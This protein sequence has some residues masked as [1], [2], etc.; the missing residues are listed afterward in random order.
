MVNTK[1]FYS[2][3]ISFLMSCVLNAQVSNVP[4]AVNYQ[5]VARTATGSILGNANISVRMTINDGINPGFTAYQETHTAIT[6]Q[7]G[8]FTIKIG[9]GNP[10]I[11]VF[12]NINWATGNKYLLV[13]YDP[14]GGTN[15]LNMGSTQLLSVPYA[16][17]AEKSGGTATPG[18][19]GPT[20]PQGAAGVPGPQGPAGANGLNGAIGTQGPVGATGAQ[21]I[22][23]VAGPTG[24]QGATGNNGVTGAVGAT[25]ATGAQGPIGPTGANGNNGATGAVGATGSTGATGATGATGT[26]GLQGSTGVSGAQGLTGLAGPTGPGWI[27][28]NL[29]YN[30]DGSLNLATTSPQ[31]LTTTSKS[32]LLSGN[33]STAPST[34]FIGTTDNQDWVIR[35]NNLERARVLSSGNVGIGTV[36]ATRKLEIGGPASTNVGVGGSAITI[37]NPTIRVGGLSSA[38]T[39]IN[40]NA[41]PM[42]VGA[43]ANGDLTLMG[44]RTQYFYVASTA[45]RASVTSTAPTLQ[46]G[47]SI[48]LTVPAG[49]TARVYANA[50]I[51]ALNTLL[52]AG[53]FSTVDAVIFVD[54]AFLPA[55][56]WNR[57]TTV[58]HGTGNSMS[59]IAVQGFFTLTAGNHTVELRANRNSGNTPV[60]IGGNASTDVNPGELTLTVIY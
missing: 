32:W 39:G 34:D 56:G 48:N 46:P 29:A 2:L 52:T 33:S 5:A 58:N 22:Q 12:S 19:T 11:G 16:L 38:S 44:S 31:N 41:Y 25:G 53:N 45:S 47:M 26:Q 30:A 18:P 4:Q 14:N 1:Y 42:Q 35:T 15:Y 20:G 8:L 40:T 9:L 3:L 43:D 59:V 51:G 6:N 27:I 57:Q 54:G 50:T 10:I 17:Y 60:N 13:E 23:G 36:T 24:A 21:G 49:Q 37:F 28:S 55:G 7:F